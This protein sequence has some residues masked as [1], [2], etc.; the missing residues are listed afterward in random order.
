MVQQ[1]DPY[2]QSWKSLSSRAHEVLPTENSLDVLD[3]YISGQSINLEGIYGLQH[4]HHYSSCRLMTLNEADFAMS[5]QSP[6]AAASESKRYFPSTSPVLEPMDKIS[7]S[8]SIHNDE[9]LDVPRVS[10]Q[11]SEKRTI[12]F[13]KLKARATTTTIRPQEFALTLQEPEPKHHN[14]V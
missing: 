2:F 4:G 9:D 12:P 11:D 7:P 6:T 14:G 8:A 3:I 1:S 13:E 5:G 10:I